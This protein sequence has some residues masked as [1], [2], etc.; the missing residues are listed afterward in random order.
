MNEFSLQIDLKVVEHV[1]QSGHINLEQVMADL[2]QI[3][4]SYVNTEMKELKIVE[5]KA[6]E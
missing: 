3:L 6:V 5:M 2:E 4:L 1:R